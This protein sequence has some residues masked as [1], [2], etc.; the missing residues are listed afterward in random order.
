LN[1]PVY[2]RGTIV[3][4][5]YTDAAREELRKVADDYLSTVPA[6][7]RLGAKAMPVAPEPDGL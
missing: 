2:V 4:V 3:S 1:I 7:K 5:P 6:E